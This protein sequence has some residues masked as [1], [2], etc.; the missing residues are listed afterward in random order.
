MWLRHLPAERT[1]GCNFTRL[2][3]RTSESSSLSTTNS[4]VFKSSDDGTD[5]S[6]AF[7]VGRQASAAS[8]GGSDSSGSLNEV[9]AEL[10]L[11]G[12][13]CA[14]IVVSGRIWTGLRAAQATNSQD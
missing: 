3:Q 11:G 10:V 7:W 9:V 8:G 6:V 4:K 14:V 13:H 2:R 5:T 12:R 1:N